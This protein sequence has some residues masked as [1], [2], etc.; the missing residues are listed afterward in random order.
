[1]PQQK[2]QT[3]G[4]TLRHGGQWLRNSPGADLSGA[5]LSGADLT[6][7]KQLLGWVYEDES[8]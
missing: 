6:S 5:D 8:Q 7:N 2:R 3:D 4:L 1:M